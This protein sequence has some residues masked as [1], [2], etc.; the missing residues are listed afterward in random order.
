MEFCV[1]GSM[2]F[3][4]SLLWN[5]GAQPGT[6][7]H[8]TRTDALESILDNGCLW[9]SRYD[10]LN[11]TSEVS[12]GAK[13]LCEAATAF[14]G[15]HTDLLSGSIAA[16]TE[17]LRN[18]F[19]LSTSIHG[20]SLSLWNGYSGDEGPVC[21]EFTPG[22]F[23]TAS[24]VAHT[25]VPIG[26]EN[27]SFRPI[28]YSDLFD[29]RAGFVLYDPA[30]Q[31]HYAQRAIEQCLVHL[32]ESDPTLRRAAPLLVR[33]VLL[34]ILLLFKEPSF[35]HENEYR[36][37][38]IGREAAPDLPLVV[39]NRHCAWSDGGALPYIELP[40]SFERGQIRSVMSGPRFSNWESKSMQLREKIDK[41]GGNSSSVEFLK[42]AIP[43]RF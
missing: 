25:S 20:D 12:Y 4:P 43:I 32:A 16:L 1:S 40:L 9:L 5:N 24:S 28:F 38:L 11:D 22:V 39:K 17:H 41:V 26:A 18:V 37:C 14:G 27:D 6:I 30:E 15:V 42:S 36:L 35:Y 23:L 29:T 13:R 3:G 33:D 31:R 7:F 10:Y 34:T 8:Y 2:Q 21:I 19:I